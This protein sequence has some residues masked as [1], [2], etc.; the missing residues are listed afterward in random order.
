M[1]AGF[2]VPR[3]TIPIL[4]GGAFPVRRIYCIGRN[5]ADHAREM[6]ADPTREAPFFFLKPADAA[7][8][9]TPGAV[10]R[11]SYQPLTA[12]YQLVG[13]P[14]Y[15]RDRGPASVFGLRAHAGF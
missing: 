12:D 1:T 9:V 4:G 13:N 3:P 15:N 6:G 8:P 10:A 14:G 11:H 2:D 5:Y 7:V